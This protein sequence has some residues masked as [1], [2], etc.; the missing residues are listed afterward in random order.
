MNF[1]KDY[2]IFSNPVNFTKRLINCSIIDLSFLYLLIVFDHLSVACNVHKFIFD[3]NL[4]LLFSLA[5]QA[6]ISSLNFIELI[7]RFF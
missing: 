7:G 6:K 5:A 1:F 4:F 2:F 3:L